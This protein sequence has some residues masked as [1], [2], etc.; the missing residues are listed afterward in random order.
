MA[1]KSCGKDCEMTNWTSSAK[2]RLETYF[3]HIRADLQAS[4]VDVAEVTEDLR[5]HIEQEAAALNLAVVTDQDVGNILGRI[6]ALESGRVLKAPPPPAPDESKGEA[7]VKRPGFALLFFGFI[8]PLGTILFE[9]LTGACAAVLFDPLP[10]FAHVLLTLVVPLSNLW[11]WLCLRQS[12]ST[13]PVWMG[14]ANGLSVGVALVYG[15]MFIPATPFA[16]IG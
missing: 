10:T 6:G 7:A 3:I 15:L 11:I 8:L 4:G 12:T 16:A 13:Q 1:L 2:N 9:F 14:L 5:R